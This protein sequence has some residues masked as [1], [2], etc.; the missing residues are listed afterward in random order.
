MSKRF[1][2]GRACPPDLEAIFGCWRIVLL[3]LI[4]LLMMGPPI[5]SVDQLETV[6]V[7]ARQGGRWQLHQSSSL[8][9]R[10]MWMPSCLR[11][12]QVFPRAFRT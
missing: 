2:L 1:Q 3:G 7:N 6:E 4:V 5:R 11:G 8:I 12:L 9:E 10:L